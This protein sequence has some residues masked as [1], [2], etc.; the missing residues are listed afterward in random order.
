MFPHLSKVYIIPECCACMT[1]NN[2]HL[3]Y[4]LLKNSQAEKRYAKW[5]VWKRCEKYRWQPRNGCHGRPVTKILITI[6]VNLCWAS[7]G[8]T[9]NEHTC[10]FTWIKIFVT[11]QPFL[12]CHLYFPTFSTGHFA[13]G[14]TPFYSLAVFE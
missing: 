12:G 9:R 4:N 8:F 14:C 1:C 5:L 13:Q 6:Q 2:Y 7:A 11:W 3:K 10:K